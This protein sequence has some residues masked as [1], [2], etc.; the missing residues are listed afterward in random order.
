MKVFGLHGSVYRGAGLASRLATATDATTIALRRVALVRWQ[1]ARR[2][3]LSAAQAAQAVGVSRASLYRWQKRPQPRSRRP[4]HTRPTTWRGTRLVDQVEALRRQYPMWGKRKIAVMLR[5]QG[6][7]SSIS[8]VGRILHYLIDRRRITPV[9]LLRRMPGPCRFRR[10]AEQRYARRLPKGTKPTQ[11][12]ELVQLD[13]LFVNVAPGIAV[14]HFTAY[15]PV[16]K[17]TNALVASSATAGRARALLEK[18]IAASPFPVKGIQVDG[19][20][21][22]MAEFEQLC[23]DQRLTLFV[24]PP[25]RPQLNGAVERTQ[26]TW[27]YEFYA[28]HDLPSRLSELQVEV[29]RFAHHF[30]YV[31][32]HQALGDL[33]PAEYLATRSQAAFTASHMC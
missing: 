9:P 10:L 33:T 5:R 13:T 27:R 21:E 20:S 28:C 17:W 6:E 2:Q 14:K 15:D 16:A 31:R 23:A 3:G 32:P 24:L 22:F 19:G 29:D 18:L 1:A 25:K 12:G 30:N 7:G 8:T 26:S 11:P 4:H